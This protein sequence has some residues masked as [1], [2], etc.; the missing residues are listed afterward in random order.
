M[1][2]YF[3]IHTYT[4]EWK[5]KS[6]HPKFFLYSSKFNIPISL[7]QVLHI[8]SRFVI[9]LLPPLK[10][11]SM[12]PHSMSSK[13]RF[14]SHTIHLP[15]IVAP[16][17]FFHTLILFFRSIFG[18]FRL[19]IENDRSSIE[20]LLEMLLSTISIHSKFRHIPNIHGLFGYFFSHLSIRFF[21]SSFN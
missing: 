5:K 1:T 4:S 13:L 6:H 3:Q 2:T 20:T 9:S 15:S 11:D 21:K 16:F 14:S 12:C 7:L 17:R 19:N 18:R 10:K 8:G